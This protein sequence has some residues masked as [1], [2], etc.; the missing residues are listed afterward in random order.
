MGGG[1]G[2]GSVAR[3]QGGERGRWGRGSGRGRLSLL[4]SPLFPPSRYPRLRPSPLP[5]SRL[6]PARPLKSGEGAWL[7]RPWCAPGPAN[8]P[9]GKLSPGP[10][11]DRPPLLSTGGSGSGRRQRP[12]WPA[13]RGAFPPSRLS[14]FPPG[15]ELGAARRCRRPGRSEHSPGTERA[16]RGAGGG[17][18]VSSGVKKVSSRRKCLFRLCPAGGAPRAGCRRC[19]SGCETGEPVRFGACSLQGVVRSGPS[20]RRAAAAC[21]S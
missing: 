19:P 14:R 15:A 3:Q 17:R 12:C 13:G 1:G 20:G 18:A 21:S 6:A 4:N 8:P 10:W 11:Q 7:W 5:G 9:P 2:P 16:R